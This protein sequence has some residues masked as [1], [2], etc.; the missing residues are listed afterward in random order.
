MESDFWRIA[1]ANIRSLK[2]CKKL[3]VIGRNEPLTQEWSKDHEEAGSEVHIN[4]FNVRYF[5]K[6]G[7]GGGD[8]CGH[9]EHRGHPQ[10]HPGRR[11]AP[12]S[13]AFF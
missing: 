4:W 7:V 2:V 10:P 13:Q 3:L 12:A 8:E 6:R 9:R 11:G 1:D 5:G